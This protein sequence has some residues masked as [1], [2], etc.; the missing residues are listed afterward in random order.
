MDRTIR[1]Q[2]FDPKSGV[3]LHEI[4]HL[5]PD[6]SEASV[7]KRVDFSKEDEFLQA[8]II[9]IPAR[10]SFRPHIHLERKQVSDRFRAQESWVVVAGQVLVHYYSEDR[11]HLCTKTLG[12]GD[13]S[14]TYRGGHGYEA[15]PSGGL[16]YEFK[17]GPYLGREIDKDFLD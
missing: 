17:T 8:A 1:E 13:M 2:I 3:L 16:V 7:L 9:E 10:H 5:T 12:V 11:E 14:I 15:G 4:V 6:A